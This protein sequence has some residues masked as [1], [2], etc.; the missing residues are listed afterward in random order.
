M[1]SCEVAK[2]DRHAGALKE[3]TREHFCFHFD[4]DFHFIHNSLRHIVHLDTQSCM[5]LAATT[6]TTKTLTPALPM[7]SARTT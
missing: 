4:F 5:Q 7:T 6:A 1:Q 2:T 3:E